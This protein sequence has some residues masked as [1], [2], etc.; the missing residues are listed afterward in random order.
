MTFQG[1]RPLGIYIDEVRTMAPQQPIF[2]LAGHS[3]PCSGVLQWRTWDGDDASYV[4]LTIA[5]EHFGVR[6]SCGPGH[7]I[8]VHPADY[9]SPPGR[10]VVREL[11][12]DLRSNVI[13]ISCI[14]EESYT[15]NNRILTDAMEREVRSPFGPRAEE[16][17][18]PI[19][20]VGLPKP[21]KF[22]SQA[23]ADAWL[24]SHDKP[25]QLYP[26]GSWVTW[27]D[28][29]KDPGVR[30]GKVLNW[31][32]SM[33]TPMYLVMDLTD[34]DDPVHASVFAGDVESA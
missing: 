21:P 15:R 16:Y 33:N 13:T 22:D 2:H 26:E 6:W 5:Q 11:V 17:A 14:D 9:S 32:V 4:V 30:R 24:A 29:L 34:P 31:V 18:T 1:Q 27:P 20:H 23:D 28:P 10:F 25:R 8:E 3:R 19:K 12:N 7:V